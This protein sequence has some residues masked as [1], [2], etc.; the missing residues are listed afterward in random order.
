[1][2]MDRDTEDRA[3]RDL[4]AQASLTEA[5]RRMED[6]TWSRA[7]GIKQALEAMW[8]GQCT[9]SHQKEDKR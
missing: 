7:M 1:M 2:A 9:V 8:P 5:R 4:R 6:A 3:V